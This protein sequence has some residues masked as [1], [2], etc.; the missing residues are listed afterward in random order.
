VRER[1]RPSESVRQEVSALIKKKTTFSI[2]KEIQ[3]GSGATSYMRKGFLI[4]EEMRK[5]LTIYEEV[6]SLTYMTLHPIPSEF[7]YI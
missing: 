7:L 1:W 4:Y 3:M 2:Y 5:Y 6:V